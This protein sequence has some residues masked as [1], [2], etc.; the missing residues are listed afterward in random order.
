MMQ[1]T[2]IGASCYFLCTCIQYSL[3]IFVYKHVE[4]IRAKDEGRRPKRKG[5]LIPVS[6]LKSSHTEFTVGDYLQYLL[7]G[8]N[9]NDG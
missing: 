5:R 9:K 4:G 3:I 7:D 6:V 2:I 1:T 8:H